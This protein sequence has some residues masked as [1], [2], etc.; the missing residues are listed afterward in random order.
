MDRDLEIIRDTIRNT[1]FQISSEVIREGALLVEPGADL[2]G[3][4]SQ[5]WAYVGQT[6]HIFNMRG[7]ECVVSDKTPVEDAHTIMFCAVDIFNQERREIILD[8]LR[9]TWGDDYSVKLH[10]HDGSAAHLHYIVTYI[11]TKA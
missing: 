8:D 10:S 3:L 11:G 1:M 5:A 6:V 2:S 7:A 4:S 9:K